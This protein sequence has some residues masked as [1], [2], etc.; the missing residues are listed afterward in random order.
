[1]L[2]VSFNFVLLILIV[3]LRGNVDVNCFTKL[4][5]FVSPSSAINSHIQ[6]DLQSATTS[7]VFHEQFLPQIEQKD[8][9]CSSSPFPEETVTCFARN[10][11]V[12]CSLYHK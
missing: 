11:D 1:M 3:K 6:N 5:K 4:N 8:K 12:N 7:I 2:I 10:A 9:N